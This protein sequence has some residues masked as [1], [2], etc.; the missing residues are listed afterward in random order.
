VPGGKNFATYDEIE[1]NVCLDDPLGALRM[2]RGAQH[3][4]TQKK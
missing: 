2:D 3:Q 4:D 1:W